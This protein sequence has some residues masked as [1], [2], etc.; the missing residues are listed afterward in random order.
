MYFHDK[1]TTGILTNIS[2]MQS[3]DLQFTGKLDSHNA[4]KVT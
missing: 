1:R 3:N 2:N 4:R